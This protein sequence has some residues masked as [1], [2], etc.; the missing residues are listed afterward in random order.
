MSTATPLAGAPTWTPDAAGSE[1]PLLL[2]YKAVA[3]LLSVSPRQVARLVAD[4]QL[5]VIRLGHRLVRIRRDDVVAFI[6]EAVEAAMLNLDVA[7][8]LSSNRGSA[9]GAE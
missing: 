4:G 5:K 3:K 6:A 8:T 9:G 2:D 1:A 7:A